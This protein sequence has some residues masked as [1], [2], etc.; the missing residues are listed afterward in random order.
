MP[1]IGFLLHPSHA[2]F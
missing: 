2:T 1:E